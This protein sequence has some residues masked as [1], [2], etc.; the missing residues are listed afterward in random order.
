M[1]SIDGRIAMRQGRFATF[2]RIHL[3]NKWLWYARRGSGSY[4]LLESYLLLLQ[5]WVSPELWKSALLR[6]L[7]I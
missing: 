3:K 1:L 5:D 7:R 4:P 6:F 2:F